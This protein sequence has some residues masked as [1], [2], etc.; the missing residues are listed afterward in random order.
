MTLSFD[1]L[2]NSETSAPKTLETIYEESDLFQFPQQD[3]D[4]KIKTRKH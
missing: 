4:K 3:S 2:Q 1:A